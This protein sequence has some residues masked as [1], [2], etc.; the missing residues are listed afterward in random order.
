MSAAVAVNEYVAV[1]APAMSTP[2]RVHWYD[3]GVAPVAETLNVA[4]C[5]ALTVALLGESVITGADVDPVPG[6]GL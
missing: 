6:I 1:V 2:V 3:S 4:N 5:P